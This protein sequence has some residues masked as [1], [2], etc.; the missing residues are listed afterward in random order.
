MITVDNL[1]KSYNSLV[2]VDGVSFTIETGETFGLLGPNGAGKTTTINMIVGILA[3]DSGSV[4]IDGV[5]DP[6]QK[7]LR[8]KIG[9]APQA[10]AIYDDLTTAENLIFFARLYG[11]TGAHLK[12]RVDWA[13]DFAGLTERAGS[14][15]KTLSGG[16][17]RRLNFA[18]AL[19][20]DP[21]ILVLD[22]PTVGVDPQSRNL[23][24]TQ[25]EQ[26]KAEGRTII[27]TTHYMEEAQRLCNRV[28]IIDHGK[29]LAMD[30]VDNLIDSYGGK[31]IVMAELEKPYSGEAQLPGQLDELNLRFDSDKPLEEIARLNGLGI[32]FS[33]LR[34]DRPDLESVFLNL[35]GR[36][37]RD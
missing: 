23:M 3:P 2:A 36:R 16:M 13:L 35:T 32:K 5:P 21:Q 6:T 11:L 18:C 14:R 10:L 17:Q 31:S 27:Y 28:A 8:R 4:A 25:V 7:Q 15:A 34:V 20:H 33:K 30:T 26:L 29:I 1:R 22:E 9:N 37:L 12:E 19:V 24:F